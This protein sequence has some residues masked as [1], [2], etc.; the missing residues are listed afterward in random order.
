[1]VLEFRGEDM[2]DVRA[3]LAAAVVKW[4]SVHRPTGE[5]YEEITP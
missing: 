4:K 2:E 5:G 3:L 1:M